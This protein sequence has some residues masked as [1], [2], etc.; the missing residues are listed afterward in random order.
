M[1]ERGLRVAKSRQLEGVPEKGARLL[2]GCRGVRKVRAGRG[3][4]V[5]ETS[6]N[7]T[8]GVQVPQLRGVFEVEEIIIKGSPT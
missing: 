2:Q 4:E 6:T 3:V 8:L 1:E 7:T 5:A